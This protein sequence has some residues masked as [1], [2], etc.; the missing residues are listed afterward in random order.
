MHL[1]FFRIET[2]N[3][4]GFELNVIHLLVRDFKSN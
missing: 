4:A 1:C 2:K 3:G